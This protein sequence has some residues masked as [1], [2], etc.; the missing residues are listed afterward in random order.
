MKSAI[1]RRV[2]A[3]FCAGFVA[4]T[5][6]AFLPYEQVRRHRRS[7][8]WVTQSQNIIATMAQLSGAINAAQSAQRGFLLTHSSPYRETFEV[9]HQLIEDMLVELEGQ[10]ATDPQQGLRMAR[11][12]TQLDTHLAT[13]EAGLTHQGSAPVDDPLPSSEERD[14]R[15]LKRN[16][17]DIMQ[18]QRAQLELYLSNAEDGSRYYQLSYWLLIGSIVAVFA[19]MYWFM[20]RTFIIRAV[21]ARRMEKQRTLLDSIIN[22]MADGLF[23]S[24]LDGKGILTNRAF[25]RQIFREPGENWAQAWARHYRFFDVEGR[26]MDHLE[27][28]SA[29]VLA[30]EQ[31]ATQEIL[32][33]SLTTSEEHYLRVVATPYRS[34]AGE[35]EGAVCF[36]HDVTE[37]KRVEH[38][39]RDVHKR[40]VRSLGE[41]ALRNKEINALNGASQKLQVCDNEAQVYQV[42]VESLGE[43]LPDCSGAIY[44]RQLADDTFQLIRQWGLERVLEGRFVAAD[45]WGLKRGVTHPGLRHRQ[46]KDDSIEPGW[47]LAC[48]HEHADADAFPSLCAPITAQGEVLGLLYIQ[49]TSGPHESKLQPD[50]GSVV[51]TLAG[52]AGL[53]ISGLRLRES[54]RMQTVDQ[55]R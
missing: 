42:L 43:L 20:Q 17:D 31:S 25:E 6:A 39:I 19:R 18:I 9:S 22:S 28:P 35:L 41:L 36:I 44:V 29:R 27:L 32:V 47:G 7:D 2:I 46:G 11:V 10:L 53:A 12:R 51:T 13:I 21:Q 3:G 30:G 16:L 52:H 48:L 26:V 23:V 37:S 5:L 24:D 45:C 15:Q 14:M 50:N 33:R 4:L 54:L 34:S 38:D 55:G 1:P 49:D 40:V 8:E